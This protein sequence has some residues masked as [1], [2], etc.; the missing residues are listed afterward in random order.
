MSIK[1]VQN[2]FTGKNKDFHTLT[3]LPNNEGDFG[4]NNCCHMHQKVAQSA[5]NRHIWSHWLSINVWFVL[6]LWL[7]ST[8]GVLPA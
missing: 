6:N 4:Q 3:K 8:I 2:D 1:V 7:L 5:V